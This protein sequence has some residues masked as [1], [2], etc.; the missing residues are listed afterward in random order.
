MCVPSLLLCQR[1]MKRHQW[2]SNC[3][4]LNS[5]SCSVVS[6]PQLSERV[7]QWPNAHNRRVVWLLARVPAALM[8]RPRLFTHLPYRLRNMV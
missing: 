6:I 1:A 3:G 2:P 8:L 7:K 5:S 4:A